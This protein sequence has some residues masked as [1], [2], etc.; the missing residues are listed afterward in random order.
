[1][2]SR[3]ILDAAGGRKDAGSNKTDSS[4]RQVKP[5]GGGKMT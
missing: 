4:L 5:G 3:R 1:M 2:T